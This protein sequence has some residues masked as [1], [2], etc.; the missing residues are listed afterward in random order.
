MTP[1][2][3]GTGTVDFVRFMRFRLGKRRLLVG[4][5]LAGALA[6][7]IFQLGTVF[8]ESVEAL[9]AGH[10]YPVVV[11]AFAWI[12]GLVPFSL[13]EL[14]TGAAALFVLVRLGLRLVRLVRRPARTEA[15][16]GAAPG[17]GRLRQLA[18]LGLLVAA[19]AGALYAIFVLVWG[20]HYARHRLEP[21]LG[22]TTQ[23]IESRE[24]ARLA[25]RV[26]AETTRWHR[27]AGL[28]VHQVSRSPLGY[29]ELSAALDDAFVR[30]GLPGDP[31][32]GATAPV[33]PAALSGLMSRLGVSGIFVPFTGEPTVNTGPPDVAVVFTAAHEKAHQRGITH[34]GEASFAA[35]LALSRVH[36]HPYLSYAGSFFAARHLLAAARRADEEDQARAWGALGPGP[37]LDLDTLNEFWA[38]YR[39]MIRGAARRVNDSYLRTMR[40]PDGAKSYGSVVR[41]LVAELRRRPAPAPPGVS[42]DGQED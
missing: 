7:G 15:A 4:A 12:S 26:A 31:G 37:R 22:L 5:A 23:S 30:L 1:E 21:Q 27:L 14:M 33:K 8:P 18:H 34:E 25:E 20:M 29:R 42:T 6:L 13:A 10:V 36:G 17:P 41:M 11:G 19:S 39:G 40:I 2:D 24:V 16:D 9:Y 38:Q 35:Y 28:S 32:P 3:G